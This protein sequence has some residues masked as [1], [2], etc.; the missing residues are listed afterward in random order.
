MEHSC[1]SALAKALTTAFLA[2]VFSAA[3]ATNYYVA[4]TGNDANNGTSEATAWK[5][6]D[7]VNQSAFTFQPGDKI[8]FQ[9]GGTYR[10]EVILGVSGTPSQPVTIGAYG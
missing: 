9:R 8:L 4:P 1:A 6:I 3:S 2:M 7:R 5:T 10:G